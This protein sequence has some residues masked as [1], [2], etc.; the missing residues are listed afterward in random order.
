MNSGGVSN[1]DSGKVSGQN[2]NEDSTKIFGEGSVKN[3]LYVVNMFQSSSTLGLDAVF[4]WALENQWQA[5]NVNPFRMKGRNYAF[6]QLEE[7]KVEKLPPFSW[8]KRMEGKIYT[9]IQLENS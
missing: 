4:Q 2:F 1:V 9:C 3:L 6:I 8:K 5:Q 7:W